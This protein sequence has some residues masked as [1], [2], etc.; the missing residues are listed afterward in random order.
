MRFSRGDQESE[1]GLPSLKSLIRASALQS[2]NRT[3]VFKAASRLESAPYPLALR[4]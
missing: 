4:S 2:S 1:L 3:V